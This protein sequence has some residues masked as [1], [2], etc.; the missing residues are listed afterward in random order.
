MF[1]QRLPL[2]TGVR[3]VNHR[4]LVHQKGF[5]N[6]TH[7]GV[8][9]VSLGPNRVCKTEVNN[10]LFRLPT[11]SP[12]R[13]IPGMWHLPEQCFTWNIP[14]LYRKPSPRRDFTSLSPFL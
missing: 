11:E 10:V 7:G 6:L 3:P 14:L 13:K 4:L 1:S 8:I 5:E 9:A 12:Q 2:R